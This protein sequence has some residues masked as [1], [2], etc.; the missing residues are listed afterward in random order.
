[1]QTIAL[2][3]VSNIFMTMLPSAGQSDRFLRPRRIS[4]KR[5]RKWLLSSCL[6]FYRC[7]TSESRSSG[8]TLPGLGWWW[9]RSFSSS[10]SG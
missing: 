3:T 8:I 9:E 10:R 4:W 7:C 5:S 2:L 6:A 1:M